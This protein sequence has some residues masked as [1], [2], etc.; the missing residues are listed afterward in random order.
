MSSNEGSRLYYFGT[1]DEVRLGDRVR[2]KRW[3]GRALTGIVCYIPGQGP[4]HAELEY[5]DVQQ[6]A[7]RC[8]DGTVRAMAYYPHERHGQPSKYIVLVSRGAGGE[9][10]P[11]E[12]LG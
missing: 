4:K 8:D 3:F 11:D 12:V 9:L 10:K 2:I 1:R 7:V 5:E 6:W